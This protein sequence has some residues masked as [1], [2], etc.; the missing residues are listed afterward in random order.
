MHGSAELIAI[1]TSLASLV[2]AC[3]GAYGVVKVFPRWLD[4]AHVISE[5]RT[6]TEQ[7]IAERQRANRAEEAAQ[8]YRL[9]ADGWQSQFEELSSRFDSLERDLGSAMRYIIDLVAHLQDGGTKDNMPNPPAAL[10]HL[11]DQGIE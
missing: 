10:Q 1:I 11:F 2:A 4:H 3:G 9:T 5:L 7:Y 8:S 6:I